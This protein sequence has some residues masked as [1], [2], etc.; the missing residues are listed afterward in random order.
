MIAGDIEVPVNSAGRRCWRVQFRLTS[1]LAATV[2]LA[3]LLFV[4]VRESSRV[5]F[6]PRDDAF[7]PSSSTLMATSF[8]GQIWAAQM[9]IGD[10]DAPTA[11]IQMGTA[12]RVRESGWPWPMSENQEV[13]HIPVI[14]CS[15]TGGTEPGVILE[16]NRALA[17]MAAP[18]SHA[19]WNLS[20]GALAA[21]AAVALSMTLAMLVAVET[22]LRRQPRSCP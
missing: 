14:M 7:S 18:A 2:C 6:C 4:N 5:A 21:N 16:P 20:Y 15:L 11:C 22:L 10:P 1:V 8:H 13:T 17:Q 9:P 19:P 12:I 3:A